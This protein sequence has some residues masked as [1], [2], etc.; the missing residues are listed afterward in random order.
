MKITNRFGLSTSKYLCIEQKNEIE[1]QFFSEK[2][3]NGGP[4]A[5][6]LGEKW[7]FDFAV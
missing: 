2:V 3:T 7:I 4:K 5:T 6:F 1:N